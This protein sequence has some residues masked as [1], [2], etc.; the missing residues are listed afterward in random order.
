M[1]VRAQNVLLL[2]AFGGVVA[3]NLALR[4][5]PTVPNWEVLPEMVRTVRYGAFSPN[6][7]FPDGKTLQPP[8]EGTIPV[9]LAP[10]HYDATPAGALRAGA[11]LRA[12]RPPDA[13]TLRRG[14][15]VFAAFCAACHGAGAVGDGPV[16]RRGFPGPPSLL[17]ERARRMEDG[18][19]FHVLTYGQGNMPA[20]AAQLS[21]G[22]R[23]AAVAHVRAL[24]RQAVP[25]A[26]GGAP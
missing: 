11:E 16:V 14:A 2:V 25:A 21:R 4:A 18:Q 7:N 3:A 10:L 20:Y 6:P 22:D 5:D 8:V 9:E 19:L 15:A 24:Q 26:A 23:W 17:A 1:S 13:A 12:P